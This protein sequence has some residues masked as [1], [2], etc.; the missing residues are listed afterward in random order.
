MNLKCINYWMCAETGVDF[1]NTSEQVND[2]KFVIS[3]P[4]DDGVGPKNQISIFLDE[5]NGPGIQ[6]IGLNSTDIIKTVSNSKM[7]HLDI[8]YYSTPDE[9]YSNVSYNFYSTDLIILIVLRLI[10][11]I[12]KKRFTDVVWIC[13]SSK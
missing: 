5:N 12:K 1:N 4:L 2:F 7:N 9:Y 13:N 6:H 11:K 8:Q 3:E 10:R